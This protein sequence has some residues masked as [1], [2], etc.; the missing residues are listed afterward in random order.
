MK[1][2]TAAGKCGV[3]SAEEIRVIRTK[4]RIGDGTEENPN[5]YANAYWSLE[6]ELL[7]VGDGKD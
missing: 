4:A 6:G 7:A 1:E 2:K 3:D 5:R